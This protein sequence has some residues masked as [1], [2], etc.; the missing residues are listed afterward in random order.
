MGMKACNQMMKYVSF[1][2]NG[3]KL[4]E[5]ALWDVF[6]GVR[7]GRDGV[8]TS[9]PEIEVAVKRRKDPIRDVRTTQAFVN[10][11]EALVKC[12]HPACLSLI[13][14]SM[15]ANGL[16]ILVTEKM[17]DGL[18]RIISQTTRALPRRIGLIQRSQSLR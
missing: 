4:A 6:P 17:A 12:K 7:S 15:P 9:W 5:G 10:G 11:V 18:D 14:F 3:A 16:F 2:E 13:G 8:A 1:N